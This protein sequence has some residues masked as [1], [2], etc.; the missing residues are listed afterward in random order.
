MVELQAANENLWRLLRGQRTAAT[1]TGSNGDE[2]LICPFV[3]VRLAFDDRLTCLDSIPVVSF[4]GC[5]QSI[6]NRYRKICS[7]ENQR[8]CV[9]VYGLE[10]LCVS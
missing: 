3:A 8:V 2:N 4:C 5:L 7:Q 9:C 10:T 1:A 6:C